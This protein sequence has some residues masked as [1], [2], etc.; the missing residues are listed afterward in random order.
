MASS[1][2]KAHGYTEEHPSAKNYESEN[3]PVSPDQWSDTEPSESEAL[4]KSALLT[5]ETADE[6]I[7]KSKEIK[8]RLGKRQPPTA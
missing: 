7:L 1:M 2:Y 4:V 6:E 5:K 8:I 3:H